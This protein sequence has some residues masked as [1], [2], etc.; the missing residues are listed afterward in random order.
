M[1]S[2]FVLGG[3][4]EELHVV[5]Y[6]PCSFGG[7]ACGDSCGHIWSVFFLGGE[8]GAFLQEDTWQLRLS[9]QDLVRMPCT[10]L[11]KSN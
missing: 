1:W 10:E 4:L 11:N 6:G 3:G 7:R 2:V 9:N 5:T 8:C